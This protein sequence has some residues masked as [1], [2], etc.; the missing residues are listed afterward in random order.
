MKK[1]WIILLILLLIII[2][3]KD[4]LRFS[5]TGDDWGALYYYYA[6]FTNRFTYFNLSRYLGNY[7]ASHIIMGEISKLFGFNPLPYY[8][9]SMVART[10]ASISF[11]PVIKKLTNNT[12][13]AY[14]S[15]I[16]FSVM[17]TG[18]ESTNWVFNMTTYLSIGVFNLF[19]FVNFGAQ[20]AHCRFAVGVLGPFGTGRNNDAAG[21]M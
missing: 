19:L 13:A 1:Y 17:Y 10:V 12:S 9:L 21:F 4:T 6:H 15:A 2:N 18:V 16:L 5:L 8:A 11:I 7:D 3:F 14:L 20:N